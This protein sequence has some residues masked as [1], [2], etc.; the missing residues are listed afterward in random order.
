M[1]LKHRVF[2]ALPAQAA[3]SQELCRRAL[4]ELRR[5]LLSETSDLLLVSSSSNCLRSP[6]STFKKGTCLLSI[7]LLLTS[8]SG[9]LLGLNRLLLFFSL[10]SHTHIKLSKTLFHTYFH[11]FLV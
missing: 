4:N 7:T 8:L 2:C 9:V 3:G 5:R 11:S 1:L 10:L 6:P